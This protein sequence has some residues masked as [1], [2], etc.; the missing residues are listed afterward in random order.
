MDAI[1]RQQFRALFQLKW[2][3]LM[4]FWSQRDELYRW[5][6]LLSVG[7]SALMAIA[8]GVLGGMLLASLP[9]A[10][11]LNPGAGKS[12]GSSMGLELLQYIWTLVFLGLGSLWM[13]SPLM[14]VIKNENLSLDI[15]RLTR[16]PIA[17]STLHAFHTLLAVF[18]PW[19]LFFYP[20]MLGIAVGTVWTSGLIA[21]G[22]VLILLGLWVALHIAWSRLLQD[23]VTLLFS[24]RY[25]REGLT[26]AIIL[27]II[28]LT[29]LPALISER[30]NFESL[31]GL[32]APSLE[33]LLYQWPVW[34]KLQPLL[35]A[36]VQASPAGWFVQGLSGVQQQD[37]RLWLT[38]CLQLLLWTGL[39]QLIGVALLRRLF[40]EPPAAVSLPRRQQTARLARYRL[41]WP[42]MLRTLVL[43]ELRTFFRS[44]LGKLS[45]FLTPLLIMILRLVGLG[46][47]PVASSHSLLLGMTVYIFMTSLFLYIN[48]FGPDQ[49][50]FKL[51]LLA[52][53]PERSLLL[54][55]NLALALFASGQ[56]AIVLILYVL[57]YRQLDLAT[58][59]FGI[60]SFLSLLLG[61]LS[62]GNLLSLRF[63]AGMDLNQTQYRQSNGTPILLGL[64]VMTLLALLTSS[65]LWL[66]R[67]HQEPLWLLSAGLTGLMALAWWLLLPFCEQLLH[68][69]R[70]AILDAV[71]R[72][73]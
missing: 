37:L 21:L 14:F 40:L 7:F 28:L 8:L 58:L 60:C 55:K 68:T 4:R 18:E 12:A 39:A 17:Y 26:L 64:Q 46:S 38:G 34:L 1:K 63:P 22:P 71:S 69:Q 29:F 6:M 42:H 27:G 67:W 57:L 45:F 52:G 61:V 59:W 62:M 44:I 9:L 70:W 43:K 10:P 32:R 51:Y 5:S 49:D 11:A 30:G 48:F 24:S 25:L 19:S 23:M 3:L 47:T 65:P 56:F 20:L 16:Y 35:S 36:L 73:D 31:Q 72:K 53:L 54:A 50:G 41:R 15:S 33:L 66:A 2:R 13:L